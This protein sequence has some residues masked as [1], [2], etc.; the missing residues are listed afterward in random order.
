MTTGIDACALCVADS[1]VHDFSRVCCTAR[2]IVSIPLKQNR[3]G[4]LERI[5]ARKP[6]DFH[7]SLLLQVKARW[8]L[9]RGGANG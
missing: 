2:Y 4:W 6:A 8:A 5:K 9:K 3:V 7:A 1:G